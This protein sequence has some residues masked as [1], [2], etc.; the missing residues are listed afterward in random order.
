MFDQL[1]N[2]K[3]KVEDIAEAHGD[4]I[5]DGL[6][7]AGDFIDGKTGGKHSNTID[8]VVDKAQDAVD[9]LG[10]HKD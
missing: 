3:G 8:T 10:K 2:L 4:K 1:K 5:S 6:Q 7:K 9:K